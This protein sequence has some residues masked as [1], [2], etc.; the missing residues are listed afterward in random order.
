MDARDRVKVN[1]EPYRAAYGSK[2]AGRGR[3]VYTVAGKPFIL[4]G[5]YRDT[6]RYAK[7]QAVAMGVTEVTVEA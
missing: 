1:T 7:T 2:P 3:W 4:S 6:L 5:T